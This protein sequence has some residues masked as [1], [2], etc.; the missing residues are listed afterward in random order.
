MVMQKFL[1]FPKLSHL[2]TFVFPIH[3][4]FSSSLTMFGKR[5]RPHVLQ[6]LIFG[7][8]DP[9]Y[10]LPGVRKISQFVFQ[11]LKNQSSAIILGIIKIVRTF[12]LKIL[13]TSK[14]KPKFLQVKLCTW[15]GIKTKSKPES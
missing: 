14:V 7:S 10:F 11:Y 5:N 12:L 2:Y 13:L 15:V 6:L 3:A 9:N 4:P 1:A 8:P